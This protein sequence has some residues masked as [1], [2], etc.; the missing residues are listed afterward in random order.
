M[1][2]ISPEVFRIYNIEKEEDLITM[3][4]NQKLIEQIKESLD[5]STGDTGQELTKATCKLKNGTTIS[6][7]VFKLT[8]STVFLQI[9]D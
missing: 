5:K 6:M 7:V 9:N 1:L 8:K 3:F 4:T 2:A